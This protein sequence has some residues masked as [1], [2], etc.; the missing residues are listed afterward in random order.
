MTEFEKKI[1]QKIQALID[2]LTRID[3]DLQ[4]TNQ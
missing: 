2:I 1:L 3:E 4:K